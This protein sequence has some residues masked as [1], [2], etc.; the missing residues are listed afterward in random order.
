MCFQSCSKLSTISIPS[1]VTKIGN[2]AFGGCSKLL[3]LPFE[4]TAGWSYADDT[5]GTNATAVSL[6]LI[7]VET[8]ATIVRGTY[9][10]KYFTRDEYA[11]F[12]MSSDKLT[13]NGLSD[14]GKTQ[15]HLVA[16]STATTIA[17]NA[18]KDVTSFENFT[19]AFDKIIC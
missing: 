13:I 19:V 7:D 10:K 8:N 12:N 15:T 4:N 2:Q 3:T 14:I 5:N 16:P 1:T 18:F 6:S 17:S 11:A 9:N